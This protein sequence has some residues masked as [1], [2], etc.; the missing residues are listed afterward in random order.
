MA[1]AVIAG[2]IVALTASTAI[3]AP[4]AKMPPNI[5]E[6]ENQEI[7]YARSQYTKDLYSA[8]KRAMA[9]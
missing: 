3:A 5:G 2:L 6:V 4:A 8:G 7:A 9:I 1:K